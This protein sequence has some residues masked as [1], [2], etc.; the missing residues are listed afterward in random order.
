MLKFFFNRVSIDNLIKPFLSFEL[1]I[2]QNKYF[3]IGLGSYF[4]WKR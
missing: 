4:I 2:I 1:K 3:A